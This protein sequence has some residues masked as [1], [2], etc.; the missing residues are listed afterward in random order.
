MKLKKR[1]LAM[2]LAATLAV[3]LS[4]CGGSGS[5][6]DPG[7]AG[8]GNSSGGKKTI[9]LWHTLADSE[10]DTFSKYVDEFNA[11]SDDVQV[12]MVYMPQDEFLTQVAVGNLSSEL[13]DI[14]RVDNPDTIGFASS[15]VLADITDYYN[16]WDEAS[17]LEGPLE[18]ATYDG[19]IY[20]VPS[21]SNNIALYYNKAML[22]EAGVEVPTTW[23]ELSEAAKALTTDAVDGFAMS[24][25]ANEE[26]T[27]QFV[28]FIGSEGKT[29]NEIGSEAGI[30]ALTFINSMVQDGSMSVDC[31]NWSQADIAKQFAAGNCAM[32]INGPWNVAV[33]KEDN[34]DLDFGVALIPK[35]ENGDYATC[36]GGENL[37]ITANADTDAAWEFIS[38][39]CS[40]EVNERYTYDQGKFSPRSDADNEAIYADDEIMLTFA[41]NMQYA[42]AR[43]DL[44]WTEMSKQIQTMLQ[45]TYTGAKTPEQAA[46][47]CQTKIDTILAEAEE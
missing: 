9:T 23:S 36:L 40:K 19:K 11:Q 45:E 20:G 16:N 37:C 28:P 29:I 44:S 46:K 32:M 35:S 22:E 5:T 26:A 1:L 10:Q 6:A 17:Y 21:E 41:E 15:G 42:I 31:I 39:F 8:G 2:T 3:G 13:G 12:E 27:F 18:S 25:I 33:V 14:L 7:S 38:W 4:A 24:A 47:D 43:H 30:D 34:P